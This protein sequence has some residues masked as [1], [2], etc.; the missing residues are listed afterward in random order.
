MLLTGN[1][2]WELGEDGPTVLL[3]QQYPTIMRIPA[4]N[5]RNKSSATWSYSVPSVYHFEQH[6]GKTEMVIY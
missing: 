3:Y 5:L 4:R 1:E 6:E 2:P